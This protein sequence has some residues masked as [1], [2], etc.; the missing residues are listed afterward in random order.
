VN[1]NESQP[2]TLN[3]RE[4]GEQ[5]AEIA[6]HPVLRQALEA[7][8]EWAMEAFNQA[9]TPDDAW[10]ARLRVMAVDEFIQYLMA[11]IQL[12]RSET[13]KIEREYEN[14]RKKKR[15]KISFADHLVA[16]RKARAEYDE[17][18]EKVANG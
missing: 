18:Q 11:V 15:D 14:M 6:R 16:A 17:Q 13:A 2:V 4:R 1:P 7:T 3:P 5:A 12:G 8:R 9:K 10:N